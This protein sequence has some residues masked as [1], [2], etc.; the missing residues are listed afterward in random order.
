M[1]EKKCMALKEIAEDSARINA[2]L[3][4]FSTEYKQNNS[5]AYRKAQEK[6]DEEIRKEQYQRAKANMKA[7]GYIAL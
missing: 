5:E 4:Q 7:K 1:K 6:A 2:E 3:E